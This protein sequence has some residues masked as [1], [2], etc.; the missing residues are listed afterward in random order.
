MFKVDIEGTI[1]E[2]HSPTI[3]VSQIRE[4]GDLP[5]DLPVLE[6]NL[7]TNEQRQLAEDE[8]IRLRP[9]MGYSKKVRWQRGC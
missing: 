8:V 5:A 9:G 1:Y 2:W 4:L 6:I 3:S 7:K